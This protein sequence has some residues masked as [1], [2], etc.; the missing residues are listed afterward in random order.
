MYDVRRCRCWD[1]REAW[2]AYIRAYRVRIGMTHSTWG[3]MYHLTIRALDER[4]A[5]EGFAR[6]LAA[7]E[8]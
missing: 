8:V 6:A 7:G 1:C 4:R 2:A 5:Q 3:P